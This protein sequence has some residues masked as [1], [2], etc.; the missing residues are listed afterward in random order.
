MEVLHEFNKEKPKE[1]L[2]FFK[3]DYY[4]TALLSYT[5]E[6][7][8]IRRKVFYSFILQLLLFYVLRF[9]LIFSQ[10]LVER[11]S[12]RLHTGK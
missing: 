7:M 1:T 4:H 11:K 3:Y 8:V 9:H 2:K 12:Y 6:R 5:E 10:R